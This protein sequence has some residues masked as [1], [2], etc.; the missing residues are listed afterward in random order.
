MIST[1]FQLKSTFKNRQSSF[2]NP[3]SA[4]PPMAQKIQSGITGPE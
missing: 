4:S 2:V 1:R 3:F